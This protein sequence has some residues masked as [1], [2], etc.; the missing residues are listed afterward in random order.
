VIENGQ[1]RYAENFVDETG[2]VLH[3]KDEPVFDTDA[4]PVGARI[5]SDQ[6]IEVLNSNYTF[7]R[8]EEERWIH[9]EYRIVK[10]GMNISSATVVVN[11]KQPVCLGE[12]WSVVPPIEVSLKKVPLKPEDYVIESITNN[13]K[14]GTATMV[15][16][17]VGKY[18]GTKKVTF[19]IDKSSL[20]NKE[21]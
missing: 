3:V 20:V 7:S 17:G 15:I 4:V 16:R 11:G 10:K 2:K 13:W 18:C 12:D 9:A 6:R 5:A 8:P 14:V 21:N 1:L 19:K